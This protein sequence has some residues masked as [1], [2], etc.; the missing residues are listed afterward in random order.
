[1]SERHACGLLGIAL[2][3]C[4]YRSRT[5]ERERALR[6]R[7][8][9]LAHENPRYGSPR[10]YVLL[11]RETRCNHKRVERIYR[12]AGLGLRRKKRKRLMR[13]RVPMATVWARRTKSGRSTL[14]PMRWPAL[15]VCAS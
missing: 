6:T 5:G 2:S 13:E 8:V 11:G 4:R 1:M 3:S 9:E 10:L 14:W 7:L 15:E 12:E